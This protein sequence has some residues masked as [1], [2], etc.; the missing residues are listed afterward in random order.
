MRQLQE[1]ADA[2]MKTRVRPI[3][4]IDPKSRV[5]AE[6]S[7]SFLGNLSMLERNERFLRE[8]EEKIKLKRRERNVA[9]RNQRENYFTPKV[10]TSKTDDRASIDQ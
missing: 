2:L 6:K 4:K 7:E 5:I 10:K 1:E 8:K 9:E 3:P